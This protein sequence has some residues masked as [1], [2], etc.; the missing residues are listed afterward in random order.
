MF[1]PSKFTE[2]AVGKLK[3]LCERC[4]ADGSARQLRAE[5]DEEWQIIKG[6]AG[7]HIACRHMP[8]PFLKMCATAT[9]D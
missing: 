1:D 5:T 9:N 6:I 3:A 7:S 2:A 8:P 4:S